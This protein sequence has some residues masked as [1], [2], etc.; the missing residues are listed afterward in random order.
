MKKKVAYLMLLAFISVSVLLFLIDEQNWKYI[1]G[2]SHHPSTP[3]NSDFAKKNGLL[4]AKYKS[5]QDRVLING[6]SYLFEDAFCTHYFKSRFSNEINYGMYEFL[7][8]IKNEKT[9]MY[10]ESAYKN[11]FPNDFVT[12]HGERY[13]FTNKIGITGLNGKF[14]SL[15]YDSEK[16][17]SPPDTITFEFKN[18]EKSNFVSFVKE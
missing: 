18:F 6:E 12:Y 16:K 14:L 1:P 2:I 13:G 4:I 7:V 3:L 5:S 17:P 10:N 15:F 8:L 9:G 11:V